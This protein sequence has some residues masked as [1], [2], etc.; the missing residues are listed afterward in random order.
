MS[1]S[2]KIALRPV[3]MAV[4]PAVEKI[5]QKYII[6]KMEPSRVF[7]G[8]NLQAEVNKIRGII[9]TLY[10]K[11]IAPDEIA[12]LKREVVN[13]LRTLEGLEK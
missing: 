8:R 2:R 12:R 9:E 7:L 13:L 5:V 4:N 3:E 11:E 10:G 6:K 1:A